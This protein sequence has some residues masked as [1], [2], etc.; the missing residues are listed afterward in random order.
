MKSEG[1]HQNTDSSFRSAKSQGKGLKPLSSCLP[2]RCKAS[3]GWA[4]FATLNLYLFCLCILC[5]CLCVFSCLYIC[6]IVF[7]LFATLNSCILTIRVHP[8]GVGREPASL[9]SQ[10]RPISVLDF[11]GFDPSR[12]LNVKGGI[13]WPIGNLTARFEASNLSKETLSREIGGTPRCTQMPPVRPYMLPRAPGIPH[14]VFLNSVYLLQLA[15]S[16]Y[17]LGGVPAPGLAYCAMKL[18]RKAGVLIRLV[19]Y[20]AGTTSFRK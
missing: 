6:V 2:Q 14:R 9:K 19:P 1:A 5:C 11:R 7:C 15:S 17:L 10:V 18:I 4:H 3:R 20:S 8:G 12:V 13:P 16:Y